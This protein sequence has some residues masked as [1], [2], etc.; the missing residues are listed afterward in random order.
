PSNVHE[1]PDR[2]KDGIGA[3]K[4]SFPDKVRG[5][6]PQQLNVAD[7]LVPEMKG[8][9]P[10]IRL[11]QKVVE[12]GLLY[13]KF[14]LIGRLEFQRIK[15]EEVKKI[16]Q[17]KWELKGDWKI[18]PLGRGFFMIRLTCEKDWRNIWGGGPWKFGNQIL[19]LSKWTPDFDPVVHRTSTA[20]V[21]VK[22]PKLGQQYWDYEILMSIA[23]GLGNPVGVDKHTLNRDFGFFAL[24]LVEID[25]AKP[26]PGKILVEEG[27]G[28]SFFQE[29]EVDKLPK[30]CP[31]CKV[32]GHIMDECMVMRR[33]R[34]GETTG[35]N[36]KSKPNDQL[37]ESNIG[38]EATVID[39][40]AWQR[41]KNKR[42]RRKKN[43][44]TQVLN[45]GVS[46]TKDA[47]R[48]LIEAFATEPGD[49]FQDSISELEEITQ[50]TTSI[51]VGETVDAVN[52]L[53]QTPITLG[54]VERARKSI[55]AVNTEDQVIVSDGLE[56]QVGGTLHESAHT[57]CGRSLYDDSH[58]LQL[59]GLNAE[60]WA[61]AGD[62]NVVSSIV[63]RKG[64]RLPCQTA[65]NE[66]VDLINGNALMDTTSLGF[67][68]SW[69][70]KRHG[71]R[72]MVQKI[73]RILVNQKW[74][75]A[76]TGWRSKI[77]QWRFFGH[78]PIIGWFTAIPKPHNIPFRLKK[79]LDKARE[80]QR[81][82]ETELGR[83]P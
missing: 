36:T 12:R 50:N 23:R 62:F 41:K 4:A 39:Q 78:S 64:G 67:K 26:I 71:D 54:S 11:L 60:A 8:N 15:L 21:W 1:T 53:N 46:G 13:C 14:C 16:A 10:S 19:R 65:V 40:Q 20:A 74:I 66:F 72:R 38:N 82:R 24:V 34:D 7:L 81:G 69:S 56:D 83:M 80:S 63:E 52:S 5:A 47:L 22:F 37:P 70:N 49:I 35:R 44:N 42:N 79:T 58:Y 75:D 9:I 57:G 48:N 28:K 27:E 43:N 25:L 32:V 17:E 77:L 59:L 31:H 2:M 76:A 55:V 3:S 6:Q 45:A 68:F 18:V 30:F 73:D 61:V 51:E 29:V 33:I